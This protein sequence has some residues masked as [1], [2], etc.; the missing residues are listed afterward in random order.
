MMTTIGPDPSNTF[1]GFLFLAG[2]GTI[3]FK[4]GVD[5]TS[6]EECF[7]IQWC[8]SNSG[9]NHQLCAEW[10]L[11]WPLRPLKVVIQIACRGDSRVSS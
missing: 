8:R 6:E 1:E 9:F 3:G 11:W 5:T 2:S 10:Y 4:S 7:E